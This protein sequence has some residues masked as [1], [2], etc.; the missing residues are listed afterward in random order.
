MATVVKLV[1]D[2]GEDEV[3]PEAVS[4]ALL[5]ANDPFAS[6]DVERVLPDGATDAGVEEQVIGGG[7]E[8]R[9]RGE[10]CPEGP[11]R[12]N[13]WVGIQNSNRWIQKRLTELNAAIFFIPSS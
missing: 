7:L 3:F 8:G 12:F 4:D 13:L 10:V 6:G 5:E 2:D 11:E 1:A 9:R